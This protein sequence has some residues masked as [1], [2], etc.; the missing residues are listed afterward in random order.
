MSRIVTT[1]HLLRL[2]DDCGVAQHASFALANRHHGYCLD[3]NARALLLMSKLSL[4]RPLTPAEQR[5]AQAYAAFV[6]HCWCAD[7]GTFRNFMGFDRNWIDS[8]GDEDAAARAFWGI[9]AAYASAPLAGIAPWAR[10]LLDQML[11]FPG[12][13]GSPRAWA[14][15]LIALE[16]CLAT[17]GEWREAEALYR[18]LAGRMR[19][20]FGDAARENWLW[21]EDNLAYE[22][23]RLCEAAIR[24][25]VRL[26]DPVLRAAGLDSL[27]WLNGLQMDGGR[28]HPVGSDSFGKPYAPPAR[29]DQQPIEAAATI[30]ACLAAAAADNDPGWMAAASA[31]MAWFHG[32]NDLGLP[33]A[34]PAEGLCCDGLHPDRVNANAGAESTLCYLLARCVFDAA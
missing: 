10:T 6:H 24:A 29:F 21:W 22:N 23:A 34:D 11:A 33:L 32:A 31:A 27:R 15:L 20:R 16:D 30:D 19:V 1:R 2:S 18:E 13:F 7:S 25:G 12:N 14:M 5:A 8:A 17:A 3:D 26:G 4:L 28:F 9:A